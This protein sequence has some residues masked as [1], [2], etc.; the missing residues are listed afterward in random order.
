MILD[1]RGGQKVTIKDVFTVHKNFNRKFG[2]ASGFLDE[3]DTKLDMLR[4]SMR[5]KRR[6]R[7]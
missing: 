3:V 7:H 1:L 2:E 5:I 6:Q 4:D